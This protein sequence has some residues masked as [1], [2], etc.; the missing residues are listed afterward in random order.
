MSRQLI[1]GLR[2]VLAVLFVC[3]VPLA[4]AG[5]GASSAWA[6]SEPRR[7]ARKKRNQEILDGYVKAIGVRKAIGARSVD[8]ITQFLIEAA[9]LTGLGGVLGIVLGV[10][11]SLLIK[12][13]LPT[14]IPLWAPIV[15]FCVS[16]G[17]GLVFGLLPAWKAARLNPI[18]ALRYE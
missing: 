11:L 7:W 14:Y 6:E 5:G 15:G 18:D 13:I 9:T 12:M 17:L 10:G 8:I 2:L 3:L 16:V 4:V 1:H